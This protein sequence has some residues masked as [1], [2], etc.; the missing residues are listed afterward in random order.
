MAGLRCSMLGGTWALPSSS[1]S[2]RARHDATGAGAILARFVLS[3]PLLSPERAN[4]PVPILDHR[5]R[6]RRGSR[7]RA[8][9]TRWW[10][11]QGLFKVDPVVMLPLVGPVDEA[12]ELVGSAGHGGGGGGDVRVSAAA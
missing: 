4:G 11:P 1:D 10:F 12:E 9:Q 6:D 7:R 5:A 8:R 2:P 3:S